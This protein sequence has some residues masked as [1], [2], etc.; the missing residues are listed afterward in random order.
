MKNYSVGE[1]I[2]IV[3]GVAASIGIVKAA[4]KMLVAYV[5]GAGEVGPVMALA[6]MLAPFLVGAIGLWLT[7]KVVNWNHQRVHNEDVIDPISCNTRCEASSCSV[8]GNT[9]CPMHGE[10]A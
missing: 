9:K 6:A 10:H 1:Y 8:C 7:F 3:I 2:G 4:Q 5:V